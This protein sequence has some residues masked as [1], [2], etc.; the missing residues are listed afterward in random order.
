MGF[1]HFLVCQSEV[2]RRVLYKIKY[3][4]IDILSWDKNTFAAEK[5]TGAK[6][7]KMDI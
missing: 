6:I 2:N 1:S 5:K 4:I 3:G 7:I